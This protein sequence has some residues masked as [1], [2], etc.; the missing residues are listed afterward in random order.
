MLLYA[1]KSC[2][3]ASYLCIVN[4]NSTM[5]KH[6]NIVQAKLVFC[7]CVMFLWNKHSLQEDLTA[8]I[9]AVI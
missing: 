4:E 8:L 3:V 7:Q 2:Y 5:C 9:L 1:V 6:V